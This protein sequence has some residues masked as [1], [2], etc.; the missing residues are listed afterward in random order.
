MKYLI[1]FLLLCI[2]PATFAFDCTILD[3]NLYEDCSYLKSIND[4]LIAGLV[5]TN[6]FTPDH[7]FV[8]KYNSQIESVK[9]HSLEYQEQGV[10]K[11]AW[12]SIRYTHNVLYLGK[13]EN[14]E[15]VFA[16]QRGSV[17]QT[18]TL[19][20]LLEEGLRPIKVFDSKE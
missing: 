6:S 15:L 3:S 1:F 8:S 10:I 20:E 18:R 12:I 19:D 13:D 5:Y 9:P 2:L 14:D 4:S 7:D 11:N 16:E 17:I